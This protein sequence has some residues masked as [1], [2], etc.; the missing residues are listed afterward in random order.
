MLD[1][2][3]GQVIGGK[4]HG[5]EITRQDF[6]GILPHLS[7]RMCQYLMLV[8]QFHLVGAVRHV[9]NDFSLNLDRFFLSHG[10]S[11]PFLQGNDSFM[12]GVLSKRQKRK[13][14]QLLPS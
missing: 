10:Q 9:L 7:A 13:E 5:H 12:P 6:D 14:L 4:L 1:S 8:F 3:P 11:I 2:T